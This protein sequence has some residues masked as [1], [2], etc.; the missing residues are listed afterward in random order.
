MD[1]RQTFH[2][3]LNEIA[4]KESKDEL[5]EESYEIL[6]S[7]KKELKILV[8]YFSSMLESIEKVILKFQN[9]LDFGTSCKEIIRIN[10]EKCLTGKNWKEQTVD[11]LNNR[12]KNIV[13]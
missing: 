4:T 1:I 8:D 6:F 10:I 11:G 13:R 5:Q 9:L 2:F 7:L 3:L 12:I